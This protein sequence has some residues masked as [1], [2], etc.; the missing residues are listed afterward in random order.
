LRQLTSPALHTNRLCNSEQRLC[1]IYFMQ[2]GTR[3]MYGGV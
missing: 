2:I 1:S 3:V